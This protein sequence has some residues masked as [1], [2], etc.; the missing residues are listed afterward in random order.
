VTLAVGGKIVTSG[1]GSNV[2]GHPLNV[3]GWLAGE[4]P[5][6]GLELR[7]GDFVTTGITT[8]VYLAQ[9]GD[10]LEADFGQA[11]RIKLEFD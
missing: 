7:Q 3:L 2:L 11:G 8:D 5:K 4:L 1:S 9:A 6:Y 10:S